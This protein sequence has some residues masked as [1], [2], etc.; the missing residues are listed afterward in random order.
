MRA[1]PGGADQRADSQLPLR[2]G[3][4]IRGGKDPALQICSLQRSLRCQMVPKRVEG[5]FHRDQERFFLPAADGSLHTLLLR[6]PL[7]EPQARSAGGSAAV[8]ALVR[9]PGSR[10]STGDSVVAF[11]SALVK[12]SPVTAMKD[13]KRMNEMDQQC[14]LGPERLSGHGVNMNTWLPAEALMDE[15]D[16]ERGGSV[17][18]AATTLSCGSRKYS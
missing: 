1:H 16:T 17:M 18:S 9:L 8:C 4:A 13:D 2:S 12:V 10:C 15:F 6:E 3:T 14:F 11:K 5:Q 7:P